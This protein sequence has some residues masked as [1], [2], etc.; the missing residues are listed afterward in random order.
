MAREWLWSW[1]YMT[2][3]GSEGGGRVR[4]EGIVK[5]VATPLMVVV[6]YEDDT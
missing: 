3:W 2:E 5:V 6:V 4:G 1:L